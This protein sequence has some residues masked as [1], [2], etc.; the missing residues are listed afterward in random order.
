MA[1]QSSKPLTDAQ[2]ISKANGF[3]GAAATQFAAL[4]PQFAGIKKNPTPAEITAFINALAPIVQAQINKTRALKPPKS[5]RAKVTAFLK[6]AQLDLNRVKADPQLLGG[7]VSPYL[8]A[9]T[10]ALKLGLEGAPGEGVCSKGGS[11]GGS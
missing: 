2:F 9:H 6:A 8:A 11:S 10:L 7:K 1:S 5:D 4:A 3:C